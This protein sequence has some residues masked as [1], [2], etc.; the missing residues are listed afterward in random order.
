[1]DAGTATISIARI[2]GRTL[3]FHND[4]TGESRQTWESIATTSFEPM[5]VTLGLGPDD[6]PSSSMSLTYQGQAVSGTATRVDRVK[7][8][9]TNRV[10]AE[11]PADT[12]DQ[13]IDWAVMVAAPSTAGEVIV[14]SVYDPWTGIS[15]VTARIGRAETVTVPAGTFP[16]HSVIY[17]VEKSRG[18]EQYQVWVSE[19]APRFMVREDFPNGASTELSRILE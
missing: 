12:V 10:S 3:R 15:R 4:V 2:D 18:T 14:F 19:D 9:M 16:A 8:K 5:S 6:D 1:M 13:R 17:R 7:G 11:L